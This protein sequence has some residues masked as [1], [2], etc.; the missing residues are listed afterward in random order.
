MKHSHPSNRS[1]GIAVVVLLAVIASIAGFVFD[2]P[3]PVLYIWSAGFLLA[4]LMVP[5]LLMPL[6]R[7][8][9]R[10][11]I[12]LGIINNH[13][14]LGAILYGVFTPI[15]LLFRIMNRDAMHRTLEPS[16]DSYFTQVHRQTDAETWQDLF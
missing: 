2:H 14:I 4:A 16:A 7:I 12:R 1:F 15:A 6:N 8:W 10:I 5:S 11:A 13:L 9:G 3:L